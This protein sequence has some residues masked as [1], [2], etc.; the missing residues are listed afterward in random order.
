MFSFLRYSTSELGREVEVMVWRRVF[1]LAVTV[2]L[3]GIADLVVVDL[4][5]K[6][7]LICG[8]GGEARGRG[9][10]V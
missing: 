3:G 1:V 2:V 8:G 4:E 10:V 5:V 7:E 6:L 9:T